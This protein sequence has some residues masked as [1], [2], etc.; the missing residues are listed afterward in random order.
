MKNPFEDDNRY[1]DVLKALELGGE[2]GSVTLYRVLP[3]GE[4]NFVWYAVGSGNVDDEP[5]TIEDDILGDYEDITDY[6]NQN[7]AQLAMFYL[8][9]AD[10]AY[11]EQIFAAFLKSVRGMRRESSFLNP[12][13]HTLGNA[14]GGSWCAWQKS[15]QL[16]APRDRIVI[17]SGFGESPV[18][19]MTID[20][21]ALHNTQQLLDT[22]YMGLVGRLVPTGSYGKA[23]QIYDLINCRPLHFPRDDRNDQL[24]DAGITQGGRWL[25]HGLE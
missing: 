1:L 24:R 23:W 22:V 6:L 2:G 20:Y 7:V 18:L 3:R 8:E 17:H 25:V 4:A 16:T 21:A 13:E 5:F 15:L 11:R 12:L 14:P 10:P 19:E 9:Y